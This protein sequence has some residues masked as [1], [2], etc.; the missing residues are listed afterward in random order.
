MLSINLKK[1]KKGTILAICDSELLGKTLKEG[2]LVIDLNKYRSFY[3]G[4][5][6]SETDPSLEQIIKNA[7]SINIVGKKAIETL[8]KFG[9]DVSGVKTIESIPHLQ[10]YRL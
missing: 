9:L 1:S 6:I 3:E 10:I 8:K 4:K 2:K 5:L 7:D